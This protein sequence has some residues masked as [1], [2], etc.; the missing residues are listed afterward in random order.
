[1]SKNPLSTLQRARPK[2]VP[3]LKK[4]SAGSFLTGGSF[5]RGQPLCLHRLREGVPIRHQ[6]GELLRR[7]DQDINRT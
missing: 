7:I 4:P 5:H 2:I 1:M 6:M 3:G